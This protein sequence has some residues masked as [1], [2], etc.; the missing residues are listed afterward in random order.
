[1][2]IDKKFQ[3][4]HLSQLLF[5]CYS[6][7]LKT[8]VFSKKK[9]SYVSKHEEMSDLKDSRQKLNTATENCTLR[10]AYLNW[11][12]K[13]HVEHTHSRFIDFKVISSYSAANNIRELGIRLIQV[14]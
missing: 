14:Q 12:P 4:C 13:V 1:M 10:D 11:I 8:K 2:Y 7:I 6:N 5:I 9:K 3:N